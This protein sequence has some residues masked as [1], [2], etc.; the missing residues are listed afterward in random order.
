VKQAAVA[1][2]LAL[3][4]QG[5]AAQMYKCVD[6]RGVTH[7]ADKPTPGCANTEVDIRASP[8][9]SGRLAPPAENAAQQEADFRRRRL[10]REE[11]ERSERAQ[12]AELESRCASLRQEHALL[13]SGRRLVQFD[14]RGERVYVEDSVRE[15]RLAEV[16]AAL[17]ECPA[18]GR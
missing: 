15:R 13:A 10:E 9:I 8:P 5:A 18:S 12:R 3:C 6:A 4:A 2:V 17:Q 1:V 14:A 11:A 16:Q 7:Y